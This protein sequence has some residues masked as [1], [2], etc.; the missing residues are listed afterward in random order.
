MLL[1]KVPVVI[2]L[3]F[4]NWNSLGILVYVLTQT[5]QSSTGHVP[6]PM[7]PSQTVSW[8][9]KK[10]TSLLLHNCVHLEAFCLIPSAHHV[11]LAIM[12]KTHQ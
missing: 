6:V 5:R 11:Q 9:V 4:P 1:Q 3:V 2:I 10:P 8:G 12:P 7:E